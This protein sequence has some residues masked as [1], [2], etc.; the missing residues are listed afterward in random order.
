MK[1]I[2]VDWNALILTIDCTFRPQKALSMS[3]LEPG[4][5]KE[6]N[7]LATAVLHFTTE[8]VAAF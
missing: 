4:Y 6:Q 7:P 1:H 5:V 3:Q 8:K 2:L